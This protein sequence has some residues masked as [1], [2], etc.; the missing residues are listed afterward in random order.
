MAFLYWCPFRFQEDFWEWKAQIGSAT[1]ISIEMA[2]VM[3][4]VR[5]QINYLHI[6]RFTSFSAHLQ[7][8]L[9][10]LVKKKNKRK[11]KAENKTTAW[12]CVQTQSFASVGDSRSCLMTG[13]HQKE[14]QYIW[15]YFFHMTGPLQ[16]REESWAERW[17]AELNYFWMKSSFLWTNENNPFSTFLLEM[18]LIQ[19]KV[20]L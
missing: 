17:Q 5:D 2:K 19:V 18:M 7:V 6:S 14:N 15:S 16:C 10:W 9:A 3:C 12:S 13:S 11:I 8:K 20:L 1:Q 4:L